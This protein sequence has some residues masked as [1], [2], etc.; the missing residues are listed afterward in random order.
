MTLSLGDSFVVRSPM[1]P[2]GSIDVFT[3]IS[4]WRMKYTNANDSSAFG[5]QN[6]QFNETFIS[7]LY[8]A[9]PEF[10]QRLDRKIRSLKV[11]DQTIEHKDLVSLNRYISRSTRRCTPF[12]LFSCVSSGHFGQE[13]RVEISPK[14]K[15][16]CIAF[17]SAEISSSIIDYVN[18][19]PDL[20][21]VRKYK[22][23]SSVV[24]NGFG[25][26][27]YTI[28]GASPFRYERRELP[29]D[30]Q[31]ANLYSR[32]QE[33][34]LTEEDIILVLSNGS[35]ENNH[36]A[37]EIFRYLL[38]L[39]F[40]QPFD[41]PS[42]HDYNVCEFYKEALN[43]SA[44]PG[45]VEV[46]ATI[47][48]LCDAYERLCYSKISSINGMMD[49]INSIKR[50]T[51]HLFHIEHEKNTR[52]VNGHGAK[53]N[54]LVHVDCFRNTCLSELSNKSRVFLMK[55]IHHYITATARLNPAYQRLKDIFIKKFGI[56]SVPAD[57]VFDPEIGI[58]A[59]EVYENSNSEEYGSFL[60]F[61]EFLFVQLEKIWNAAGL[62]SERTYIDLAEIDIDDSQR[63]LANRVTAGSV[64]LGFIDSGLA[65]PAE[66]CN[67]FYLKY[68]FLG[69]GTELIGRFSVGNSRLFEV[70]A[71]QA[72]SFEARF[73]STIVAEF[74]H[75]DSEDNRDVYISP[76]LF[77][78]A[79]IS[80]RAYGFASGSEIMNLKDLLVSFNGDEVM[81]KTRDGR[82]VIPVV[83]SAVAWNRPGYS[84][85]YRLF[86]LLNK[87]IT[88]GFAWPRRFGC[89]SY[90]PRV[91]LND[92]VLT[93]ASWLIPEQL[94]NNIK[95]AP[96]K[97]RHKFFQAFA[98]EHKL[99]ELLSVGEADENLTF[100]WKED[101][102]ASAACSLILRF[103]P[104]IRVYEEVCIASLPD[105]KTRAQIYNREIVVPFINRSAPV[106]LPTRE[107]PALRPHKYDFA[108]E[109]ISPSGE[110]C[111]FRIE[112]E[113][114]IIENF[115][116]S[117]I[118]LL[119]AEFGI[120]TDGPVW[121]F[122]RFSDGGD[123][124]RLRLKENVFLRGDISQ[125]CIRYLDQE[126]AK[127]SVRKWSIETYE[128]EVHRY[129]GATVIAFV[130][131]IFKYDSAFAVKTINL[132]RQS[133]VD[134]RSALI[135]LSL[136]LSLIDLLKSFFGTI[137]NI[138]NVLEYW[139]SY[140][141]IN[142]DIARQ[143]K[144]AV[145]NINLEIRADD[146]YSISSK[147]H[148]S[149]VEQLSIFSQERF[150][151]IPSHCANIMAAAQSGSLTVAV[152][153]IVR[154]I[155]HMTCNRLM[156]RWREEEEACAIEITLRVVKAIQ[157]KKKAVA[158]R[159]INTSPTLSRI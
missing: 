31:L 125:Q 150:A 8:L 14:D 96:D 53:K 152:E 130:E 24:F 20:R 142:P 121:F 45:H 133:A 97:D 139:K 119:D 136:C 77:K 10:W 127:G 126:V 43:R 34:S 92:M 100:C 35:E 157:H 4:H 65:P 74:M 105:D 124:I 64:I 122:I 23:N 67:K 71:D 155:F 61:E 116:C 79:I 19:N 7:A 110:W 16:S 158:S 91:Q 99:P 17:P 48:S 37:G 85:L 147:L 78:H 140:T 154:S 44:A 54:N 68:L 145:D 30:R 120:L 149:L 39:E 12:G 138:L 55:N 86:P 9:A 63:R 2:F 83:S 42:K 112:G 108:E 72:A 137:E 84:N 69:S 94:V 109:R 41:D 50:L 51:G 21:P 11:D 25:F 128:R 47:R 104:P 76:R 90:L 89:L 141:I 70:A 46:D 82:R 111:Y 93:P 26:Y 115:L 113:Q 3:V 56:N 49:G 114:Y 15:I 98:A 102:D 146:E 80:N 118:L 27:Y 6:F 73:S 107:L 129:G 117:L 1:L 153:S 123:H 75:S 60:K 22:L 143:A 57:I 151:H 36:A 40:L 156:S 5:S 159:N 13:D 32:L 52:V 33:G 38:H 131:E 106:D 103:S 58:N 87:Q 95:K 28:A 29:T 148:P 81:L 88:V 62:S 135:R 132:L 101:F 134:D 66:P 144:S 18:R 59:I